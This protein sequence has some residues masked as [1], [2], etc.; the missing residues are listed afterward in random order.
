MLPLLNVGNYTARCWS[1]LRFQVDLWSR[2]VYVNGTQAYQHR[3]LGNLI[4][5]IQRVPLTADHS[6][7]ALSYTKST[8]TSRDAVSSF[9]KKAAGKVRVHDNKM[10]LCLFNYGFRQ[11]TE[12]AYKRLSFY[13]G[14]QSNKLWQFDSVQAPIPIQG[15]FWQL[16]AVIH[17]CSP[18]IPSPY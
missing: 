8:V 14:G 12:Q 3:Q 10:C 13:V 11:N 7:A 4:I 6:T 16:V 15:Y 1:A 9:L 5:L 17:F 18:E 2:F